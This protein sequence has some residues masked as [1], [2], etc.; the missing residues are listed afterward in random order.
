M[1]EEKKYFLTWKFKEEF[2]YDRTNFSFHSVH[3]TTP[4]NGR[5][6]IIDEST[7]V[8]TNILVLKKYSY[9]ILYYLNTH[10]DATKFLFSK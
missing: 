3:E 2:I 8:Y 6:I 5:R 9:V 1:R 4:R 7:Y 10:I